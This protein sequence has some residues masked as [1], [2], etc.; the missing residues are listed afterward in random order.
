MSEK[1]TEKTKLTSQFDNLVDEINSTSLKLNNYGT[2]T[3]Y[4]VRGVTNVD[5]LIKD[6]KSQSSDKVEL[7][8]LEINYKY[9]NTS[10][11]TTTLTLINSDTFTEWN[12]QTPPER[13]RYLSFNSSLSSFVTEY[14]DYNTTDNI[15]KWNQIDIPI[16]SGE[17]VVLKIRYKYNIGQPFI[18]IYTPWSDELT[19]DLPDEYSDSV[20]V[21]TILE[22]NSSDTSSA[23]FNKTFINDGY[24][25]H[26]TDNMVVI[27]KVFYHTPD[28]IYSGFNTSENNLLSLKEKLDLM[29]SDINDYKELFNDNTKSSYKVS[30]IVEDVEHEL[31]PNDINKI[32]IYRSA[33]NTNIF[34]KLAFKLNI[35]YK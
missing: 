6:I 15:I 22:T 9:K 23:A 12:I 14:V 13:N 27:D 32:N 10:K 21:Q 11:D 29:N 8:G 2:G 35:E 18:D 30:L 7:I 34:K 19:I 24:H 28:H 33:N 20:E 26:I 25:E 31:K 3:K 17:A 5:E 4:R 1:Q 16:T